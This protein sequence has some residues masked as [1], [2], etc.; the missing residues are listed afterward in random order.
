MYQ[1]LTG[2]YTKG[3]PWIWSKGVE[4]GTDGDGG[5][6][7]DCDELRGW[8]E[9]LMYDDSEGPLEYIEAAKK[10]LEQW[11]SCISEGF[12]GDFTASGDVFEDAWSVAK[13][14]R[15][16]LCEKVKDTYGRYPNLPYYPPNWK[17][18]CD[19]ASDF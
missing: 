1:E 9:W 18:P 7:L 5:G 8:L 17:R 15:C 12:S 11:E 16:W 3:N 14:E 2:D 13:K 10:V 4:G 6:D 19:C